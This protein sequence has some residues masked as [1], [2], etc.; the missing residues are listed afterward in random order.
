VIP[1]ALLTQP[2]PFDGAKRIDL[3]EDFAL[4]GDTDSMFEIKYPERDVKVRVKRASTVT[5]SLDG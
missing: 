3:G 1:P 2:V 4:F 5:E